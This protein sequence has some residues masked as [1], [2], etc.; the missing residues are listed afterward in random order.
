MRVSAALTCVCLLLGGCL[1]GDADGEA[2]PPASSAR[3][4]AATIAFNPAVN[5]EPGSRDRGP[6]LLPRMVT[7]TPEEP[8]VPDDFVFDEDAF[9]SREVLVRSGTID[10]QLGERDFDLST[11]ENHGWYTSWD[12]NGDVAS[13]LTLEV[14]AEGRAGAAMLILSFEGD[15]EPL[16]AEVARG[17]TSPRPVPTEVSTW[18][19]ACYG[20]EMY[21]WEADLPADEVAVTMATAPDDQATVEFEVTATFN[22]TDEVMGTVRA[23]RPDLEEVL[24][25]LPN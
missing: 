4:A 9:V 17:S 23:S 22:G 5:A 3:A 10:G 11:M 12:F 18:V 6:L 2:P 15:L 20:A 1:L 16:L 7:P 8:E 21:N 24:A 13:Y 25:L 14:A 19:V